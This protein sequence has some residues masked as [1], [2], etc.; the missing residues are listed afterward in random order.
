MRTR[1]LRSFVYFSAG[2]GLIVSIFAA[3][4][5]YEASLRQLCTFNSFFSCGAVD[6]SGHTLTLGIPDYLWGIGGF[7]LILLVA[8]IAES[9]PRWTVG[10]LLL[11]GVTGLGTALTLYFLWVQL[12]VIGAFC[13][14]CAS[15]YVFG[16][17]SFGG[18][19]ALLRRGPEP[20][21]DGADAR[22]DV[23]ASDDD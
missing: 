10:P 23:R 2:V 21:S 18:A 5:Y 17:L 15:A 16:W 12:A 19:V 9:R 6:T 4:E 11:A 22:D 3:V 8:G 7:V 1:T 14:I 20:P 13:V